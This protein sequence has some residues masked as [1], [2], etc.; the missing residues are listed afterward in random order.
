MQRSPSE[1]CLW[2]PKLLVVLE[3]EPFKRYSPSPAQPGAR[4]PAEVR[5]FA[6]LLDEFHL[7]I[8]EVVLQEITELRVCV[9]RTED[10]QIQKG[11]VQ[12][13]HGH[14]GFHGI[15]SCT[16]LIVGQ[17]LHI[18]EENVAT[19]PVLH[20]QEMLGFP[21]LVGQLGELVH[22]LQ[23]HIVTGEIEVQ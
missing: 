4:Q 5:W 17:F 10:M 12:V 14:G 18:L 2:P 3:G 23:S 1:V 22:A 7:L 13:L 15:L 21:V 8:Q 16:R 9:G 19:A 11:L 6:H 20:L